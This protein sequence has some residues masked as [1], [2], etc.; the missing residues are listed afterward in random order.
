MAYQSALHSAIPRIPASINSIDEGKDSSFRGVRLL[1]DSSLWVRFSWKTEGIPSLQGSSIGKELIR[2]AT[3]EEWEDVLNVIMLSLS[4]DSAWNDYFSIAEAYIKAAITRI[5]NEE[6][7]LCLVIPKGNRLIAASLLDVSQ[8]S[9]NNLISGPSVL[10]EYR[11]RG[12]G[13]ALLHAS[14][15]ALRE[16]GLPSAAGVTRNKTVASRHV[17]PK[18]NSVSEVIP[19]GF[20]AEIDK[21][22]KA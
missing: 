2:H 20:L 15:K 12:L 16:R 19:F 7:P 3:R 11:N 21:Q 6:E 9:F 5:F 8:N 10:M 14:L 18:Y 1:G 17:Y 4:M 13:T 22:A